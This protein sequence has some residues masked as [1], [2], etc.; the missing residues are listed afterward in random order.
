MFRSLKHWAIA[1][2]LPLSAACLAAN[3]SLAFIKNQGQWDP[4]AKYLASIGGGDVW[5]TSKGYVLDLHQKQGKGIKGHVVRVSFRTSPPN[6][7]SAA[8]APT[9]GNY[10]DGDP[11]SGKMNY[12]IGND[13]TKW[14]TNVPRFA[15][16]TAKQL[17]PGLDVRYYFDQGSPRY[18]L[19]LAPGTDPASITM[20]FE[21]EDGLNLLPSGNLQIETSLGPVEERGLMAYQQEGSVKVQVPCQMVVTGGTVH[22]KTASYDKTKPLIIDPLL[23][24]TYWDTGDLPDYYG[25]STKHLCADATGNIITGGGT[26]TKNLPTT[27]GAYQSSDISFFEAAY[28]AKLSADGK[29]LVFGSYLS[30]TGLVNDVGSSG[31]FINAVTTDSAGNIYM[32]GASSE[33]DFP[34]TPG[35]FQ[36][37][38]PTSGKFNAFVAEMSPNGS[39]LIFS[40]LLGGKAFNSVTG[41]DAGTDIAV[42]STGNVVV[43]GHASSNDFP[44]TAGS[45]KTSD[46]PND[47]ARA[48][49]AKISK[50]GTTLLASTLLPGGSGTNYGDSVTGSGT[51][52]PVI[53]LDSSDNVLIGGFADPIYFASTPSTWNC[54][55]GE[56]FVAKLT[57]DLK[58]ATFAI[59]LA[60][61][62]TSIDV[63]PQ[64]GIAFTSPSNSVGFRAALWPPK[65][66]MVGEYH[67]PFTTQ[68]PACLGQ[69]SADGTLIHSA[70]L[71][72]VPMSIRVDKAGN[73]YGFGGGGEDRPGRTLPT[74]PDAYQTTPGILYFEEFSPA[75][76]KLLYASYVTQADLPSGRDMTE[77]F[78]RV[79]VNRFIL[80]GDQTT[81]LPATAGAYNTTAG[82]DFLALFSIPIYTYVELNPSP[83]VGGQTVT[84]KV[85]L[86]STAPLGGSVITLS[87]SDTGVKVPASVTVPVGAISQSFTITTTGVAVN[88]NATVSAKFGVGVGTATLTRIPATIGSLSVS[89]SSIPAGQTATGT[90]ALNGLAGAG[91]YLVVLSSSNANVTVPPSVV[92][93]NGSGQGTFQIKTVVASASYTAQITAK[94]GAVSKTVSIEVDPGLSSL[95]VSPASVVAG[96]TAQGVIKLSGKAGAA[97]S[98]VTL[99][100]STTAAT[101]PPSVTVPSGAALVAFSITTAG[102]N[103]ATVATLTAKQGALSQTATLTI[104]PAVLSFL[105][106]TPTSV[107]GGTGVQAIVR[108]N[109]PAGPA[110]VSVTLTSD[111]AVATV[112]AKVVIAPGTSYSVVVI[113]TKPVTAVSTANIKAGATLIA[114]LTVNP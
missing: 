22:F 52:L 48:F 93:F 25:G 73:I 111:S 84:G 32:T 78:A 57:S 64:G 97:G 86:P 24:C 94:L 19:I 69:F 56:G 112:P 35:V 18:D 11:L 65:F 36:P 71:A 21:G 1:L 108:L 105:T 44:I 20:N 10:L 53:G 101:V 4:R 37:K 50:G 28:V 3:G 99:S 88:T 110:G 81:N 107:K 91:G 89:A 98:V 60:G 13:A 17:A 8:G 54:A 109:G 59:L 92:I 85:T 58:Q 90:V 87:S 100:S 61:F 15:G 39:T 16:A 5:L 77:T 33:P 68:Y 42:G 114:P 67:W 75:Q 113:G 38:N 80:G 104:Q 103:A 14:T 79:S 76:D 83:V 51:G 26:N 95:S 46:N 63:T 41:G 30:G 70:L 45:Y 27:T 34:T 102:V 2:L 6:P 12:F 40:T 31:D 49:V 66:D 7:L 47:L 106:L 9:R 72:Y 74:T 62:I 96:A 29:Q 23:F 43:A 55:D 82:P